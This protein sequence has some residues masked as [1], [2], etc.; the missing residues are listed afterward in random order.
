MHPPAPR[1]QLGSS[2]L[3]VSPVA[4]GCWPMS[5]VSSLGIQPSQC[6]EAIECA[7]HLGI[8][9]FDTAYSYG[10]QG[11]SD[12]LLRQVL[13][14]RW[15]QVVVASKVG[16]HYDHH[17]NRQLDASPARLTADAEEIRQ[18]LGVDCID[19]MYLHAPDGRTPVERS[20]EALARLQ[21]KGIIRS[22]GVSNT[23]PEETLAF[24]KI[25]PIVVHQPPFNM[26]QQES[27]HSLRPALRKL[28]VGA[29]VYWPLMKGL[30]AGAIRSLEQLDP[31]DR[32]LTYPMFQGK[33]WEL[34]RQFIER[35]DELAMESE[36]TIIRLVV[37]WTMAQSDV[38]TVLCGARNAQQI[39][40]AAQA[41]VDPLPADLLERIERL[42]V[43]RLGVTS[44]GS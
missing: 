2:D 16:T 8:N 38:T 33:Q 41:M 12:R 37:G 7:L 15:D 29:A 22:I 10:K 13:S 3:C 39:A 36:T 18:R 5:G 21:Q 32:R 1:R 11:E 6:V 19:L 35:L 31:H 40:Q 44:S 34:N 25:A 14:G 42:V 23:S 30:L 43:E 27:L 20:A 9:H 24:A 26:L 28:Q 17:G 4:L